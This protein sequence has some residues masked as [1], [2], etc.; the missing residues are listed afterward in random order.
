VKRTALLCVIWILCQ[1][2]ALL[3]AL[4]M[5]WAILTNP[6]R[7]WTIAKA[8]DRL[9]NATTNDNQVQTISS[10]AE[11]ARLKGKRWGCWLCRLLDRI[12]PGHCGN[13]V[14]GNVSQDEG[15]ATK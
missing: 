9:G 11:K 15:G 2:A 14:E 5:G 4:R 13:S 7:A 12:D 1:I 8:Y 10:R 6:D 3:S